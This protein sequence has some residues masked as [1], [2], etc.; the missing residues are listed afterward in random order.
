MPAT[1]VL[2]YSHSLVCMLACSDAYSIKT[3]YLRPLVFVIKEPALLLEELSTQRSE[4]S[5]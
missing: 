2:D 1:E 5:S 4:M 3:S